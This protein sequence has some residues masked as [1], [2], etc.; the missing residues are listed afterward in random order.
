MS[1]RLSSAVHGK[2]AVTFA[3]EEAEPGQCLWGDYAPKFHGPPRFHDC[4][5]HEDATV[6]VAVVVLSTSLRYA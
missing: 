3:P 6:S 4:A 5:Q 1:H 2:V